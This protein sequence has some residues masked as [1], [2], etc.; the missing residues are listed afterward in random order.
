MPL[1]EG[2]G[3][4][5]KILSAI[6]AN[7]KA[8]FFSFLTPYPR[9]PHIQVVLIT[10]WSGALRRPLREPTFHWINGPTLTWPN[11]TLKTPQH[12]LICKFL[13]F[14][15]LCQILGWYRI[16]AGTSENWVEQMVDVLLPGNDGTSKQ[17]EWVIFAK[18]MKNSIRKIG[19]LGTAPVGHCANHFIL[20][21]QSV[22]DADR[23]RVRSWSSE[24]N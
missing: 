7:K 13:S 14:F 12:H 10:W 9:Y 5:N 4:E 21:S 20:L 11:K 15:N 22:C 1:D 16:A 17:K 18:G 24:W 19:R 3:G 6:G 8:L 2:G 23:N